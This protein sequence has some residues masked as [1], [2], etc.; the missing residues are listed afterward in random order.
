MFRKAATAPL[1]EPATSNNGSN[2]RAARHPTLSWP[3]SLAFVVLLAVFFLYDSSFRSFSDNDALITYREM[4]VKTAV[5][6]TAPAAAVPSPQLDLAA[7]LA[8]HKASIV[9]MGNNN[10]NTG[11]YVDKLCLTVPRQK[12]RPIIVYGVGAG[13]DISWD[14]GM[15]DSFGATVSLF[16]PTEKSIRYTAPL[17]KKYERLTHTHE[18]LAARPGHLTF[19]LPANP[20][21]VSM[22]QQDLADT[23]MT[24]RVSVPVN[25]LR[26]WMKERKHTY[27]DILK[28]DIEGS[29]YPVLEDLVAADFLPF[30]QLL[31]E[32]HYRFLPAD[33]KARHPA[34]LQKLQDKGFHL[35]WL[36]NGGQEVGFVKIA[37]LAYC[38]DG[39]SPR[40]AGSAP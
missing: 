20:A 32:W 3:L 16:D 25:S 29:E 40:H 7:T 5:R 6:T 15:I 34:I 37:D 17:L 11:W 12:K 21:H 9:Y 35:L 14:L 23:G 19:A 28:I 10:A 13:E 22:R 1:P 30:T 36:A 39:V 27:L 2:R 18:G 26:N 33:E 4:A 24:R 38:Q 8:Q 31:V